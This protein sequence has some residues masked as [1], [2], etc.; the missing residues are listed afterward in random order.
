MIKDDLYK[1]F[2]SIK[3]RKGRGGTYDYVSWKNVADRMNEL[4]GIRWSSEVI[5]ESTVDN[6]ILVRVRV[7]VTDPESGSVSYQEGYGGA[8]TFSNEEPGSSRKSA[9]SRALKDACKKWGVGLW[10]E[11][12]DSSSDGGH[13]PA[14]YTAPAPAMPNM[15]GLTPSVPNIPA[16]SMSPPT[17]VPPAVSTSGAP[18]MPSMP[19]V[20]S[21]PSMPSAPNAQAPTPSIP[22]PG[23]SVPNAPTVNL[24]MP[25]V[26]T[27]APPIA[28]TAPS[29]TKPPPIPM[30]PSS[31]SF[32]PPEPAAP[33]IPLITNVQEMAIR[34]QIR[35]HESA[36]T[37]EEWL[38]IMAAD[39]NN[40]I[41]NNPVP[42]LSE[43]T[44]DEAVA[45]ITA[46][47]KL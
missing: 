21:A 15:A 12:D 11:E 43:L 30:M 45:L 31:Q 2:D 24:S 34:N 16:P 9:Y 35:L 10:L 46:A 33:T 13:G 39:A 1:P 32:E 44:Y 26:P 37:E 19:S 22:V 7:T 14:S 4:F 18:I 42:K 5:T 29:G 20:V 40:N 27:M 8:A 6:L 23:V 41:R 17:P 25:S 3:S 36:N 28:T 47:K 38:A